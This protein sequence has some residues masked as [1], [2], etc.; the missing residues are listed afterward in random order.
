MPKNSDY[1][2][3]DP[4]RSILSY[5]LLREEKQGYN[6]IFLRPSG[7]VGLT[8]FVFSEIYESEMRDTQVDRSLEEQKLHVCL[9]TP[10]LREQHFY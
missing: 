2:D 4:Y 6:R 10:P 9:T 8:L 7:H 3:A 5:A 1:A